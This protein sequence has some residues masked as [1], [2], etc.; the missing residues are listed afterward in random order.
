MSYLHLPGS[1]SVKANSYGIDVTEALKVL[2]TNM[3][4][5]NEKERRSE[6]KL[7]QLAEK[8]R[9]LQA[10]LAKS[11]SYLQ[12]TYQTYVQVRFLTFLLV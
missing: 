3:G 7:R 4:F 9:L 2:S 5:C 10:Q 11:T 12:Q 8:I 1:P 6:A